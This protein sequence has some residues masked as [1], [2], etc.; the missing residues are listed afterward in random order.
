MKIKQNDYNIERF[1][2][3]DGNSFT[4]KSTAK[5]F[6]ILSSGLY[7]DPITAI[8]R[9]LSCNAYDSHVEAG[10]E[11]IPFLIHLPNTLEPFLS[12]RDF[13]MGLSDDD[14]LHLYTTYFDS[15]KTKSN[16]YIGAL[17]LGSKSP[18]SYTKSYEVI[19]RYNGYFRSYHMFI[20]EQGIPDVVKMATRSTTDSNGLEVKIGVDPSDFRLF[21]NKTAATLKHF[22]VKPEIVGALHFAFD[23]LPKNTMTGKNW[24]AFDSS[25]GRYNTKFTAVQGNVQYRVDVDQ[26]S[27]ELTPDECSIFKHLHV[28]GYFAIGDLEVAANREEIRYDPTTKSVLSAFIK[29]MINEISVDVVNKCKTYDTYWNACLGL[30]RISTDLFGN[31]YTMRDVINA[32]NVNHP[33]LERY[34]DEYGDV[35]V[36]RGLLCHTVFT[37]VIKYYSNRPYSR[38]RTLEQFEPNDS[39]LVLRSDVKTGAVARMVDYAKTTTNIKRIILIKEHPY[40]FSDDQQ[41]EMPNHADY[42]SAEYAKII[43][44][45]GDPVIHNLS[46]LC[47]KLPT[48]KTVRTLKAFSYR[49]TM[50]VGYHRQVVWDKHDVDI[51]GGGI[52]FVLKYGSSIVANYG[53]DE[54]QIHW[55]VNKTKR[56]IQL[57]VEVVNAQL[58]TKYDVHDVVGVPVSTWKKIKNESQWID[59]FGVVATGL[60]MMGDGVSAIQRAE[61]TNNDFGIMASIMQPE[62]RDVIETLPDTS[63]FRIATREAMEAWNTIGNQYAYYTFCVDMHQWLNDSVAV[64]PYFQYSQFDTYPLFAIMETLPTTVDEFQAVVEYITLMD[65]KNECH[66]L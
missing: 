65:E 33:M 46:E 1:G 34:L 56:Y 3:G 42:P 29:T 55:K 7:T 5:S 22:T 40:V 25:S 43:K 66:P 45:L 19:S 63:P 30:S 23:S 26:L 52:Y 48:E 13:G 10:K 28:I 51:D 37:Y 6:E 60:Q 14:V 2:V 38:D 20:N 17:G 39:F 36:S 24:T 49:D 16:A 47:P 58:G 53:V 62:I 9:E 18:F 21:T 8:I 35:K 32:A 4:I 61:K 54:R 12:I 64:D 50:L 27:E 44:E 57:L 41:K 11:D 15:T 59:G 31:R